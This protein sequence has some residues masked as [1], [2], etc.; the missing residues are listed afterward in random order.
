MEEYDDKVVYIWAPAHP[1]LTAYDIGYNAP[2][3]C[4]YR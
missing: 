1:K 4:K 2:A 3:H